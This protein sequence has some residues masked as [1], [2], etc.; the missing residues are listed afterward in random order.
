MVNRIRE[1]REAKGFSVRKVGDEIGVAGQTVSGWE[2]GRSVPRPQHRNALAELFGCSVDDLFPGTEEV[3]YADE[4][5]TRALKF[6]SEYKITIGDVS[7]EITI[8]L[9]LDLYNDN[10]HIQ[11]SHYIKTPGQAA[12]YVPKRHLGDTEK[13]AL[14]KAVRSLTR[15][16]MLAVDEGHEPKEGWFKQNTDFDNFLTKY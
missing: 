6:L 10:I 11:Q 7:P 3:V 5:I 15:H 13:D 14:S 2:H 12:M 8:R 4:S 9:Y 1:F 16:Y